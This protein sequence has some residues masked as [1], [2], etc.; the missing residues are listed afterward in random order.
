MDEVAIYNRAISEDEVK[1]NF[2]AKGFAA[3]K[4]ANK[5]TETWGRI[6]TSM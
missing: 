6:K 4:S 2:A 3:V 5:I 1:Q